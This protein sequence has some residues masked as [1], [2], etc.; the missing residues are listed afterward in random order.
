MITIEVST[1]GE[2]FFVYLGLGVPILLLFIR[3]F[4]N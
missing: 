3:Y 1:I 4:E 2:A